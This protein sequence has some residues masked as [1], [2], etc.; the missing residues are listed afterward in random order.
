MGEQPTLMTPFY[1]RFKK[2]ENENERLN[3]YVLL[4]AAADWLLGTARTLTKADDGDWGTGD[5]NIADDASN[6]WDQPEQPSDVVILINLA[7]SFSMIYC[8]F[9]GMKLTV[10]VR[11]QHCKLPVLHWLKLRAWGRDVA[12]ARMAKDVI[13]KRRTNI[14]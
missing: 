10:S 11:S 14:V 1:K 13:D 5:S 9:V 3:T 7:S 4:V 8:E 12:M 2:S 6:D